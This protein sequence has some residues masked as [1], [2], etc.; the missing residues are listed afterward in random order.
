MRTQR[1][2][3]KRGRAIAIAMMVTALGLT[4]HV[5]T[6][7]AT[8]A[9]RQFTWAGIFDIVGTGFPEGQRQATMAIA[10]VDTAYALLS[11]QGPPGQLVSFKV[12][13][14]SAHVVWSL[15]ADQMFVDLRGIGDS[16]MGEW[17]TSD[18]RGEIRGARRH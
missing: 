17:S 10:K 4:A 12:H 9:E 1:T 5:A 11:L 18:W 3:T 8:T 15:G 13:G 2:H 16:L 6:I 7:S 14:D